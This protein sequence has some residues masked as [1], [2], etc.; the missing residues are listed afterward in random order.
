ML[1]HILTCDLVERLAVQARSQ[2]GNSLMKARIARRERTVCPQKGQVDPQGL[3][4]EDAGQLARQRVRHRPVEIAD[5]FVP[6]DG[7]ITENDQQRLWRLVGDPIFDFALTLFRPRIVWRG[8]KDEKTRLGECRL[9]GAGKVMSCGKAR[10]VAKQVDR[11]Q[12]PPWF[13]KAV[14]SRLQ[15]RRQL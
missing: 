10:S 4:L 7:A 1:A 8:Q 13:G 3:S 5:G 6:G 15:R 14:E 9:D 11:T 2:H 12:L